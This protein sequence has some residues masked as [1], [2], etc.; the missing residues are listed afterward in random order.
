MVHSSQQWVSFLINSFIPASNTACYLM[1]CNQLSQHSNFSAQDLSNVRPVSSL[2]VWKAFVH[3]YICEQAS[4]TLHHISRAKL[5]TGNSAMPRLRHI[6]R[7]WGLAVP[8]SI[9]KH[10]DWA[11]KL[12]ASASDDIVWIA[13]SQKT[14]KALYF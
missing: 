11:K 5:F 14:S 13:L 10:L 7:G 9:I 6:L 12:W 2:I 1:Q 3:K 8:R 4:Y